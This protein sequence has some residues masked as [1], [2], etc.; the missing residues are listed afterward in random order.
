MPTID[1]DYSEFERMLGMA[2]DKD[3]ERIGEV[4]AFAKAEL[5]AFDEKTGTMSVEIKDTNRADL[6]NVEGLVRCL[7]GFLGL[8]SGLKQYVASEPVC[9]VRVDSRLKN[10]RPYIACS[11]VKDLELTD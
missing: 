9:E 5:K 6:W 8:E 2:L 7:R 10:I 11:V 3:Q 1:I 4:L